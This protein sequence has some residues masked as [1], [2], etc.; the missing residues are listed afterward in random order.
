MN[1]NQILI[2]NITIDDNHNKGGFFAYPN[3]REVTEERTYE[4]NIKSVF[5]G[6]TERLYDS[7]KPT[8][9][10]TTLDDSRNGFVGSSITQVPK[11]R[12]QGYEELKKIKDK[13]K[14][15]SLQTIRNSR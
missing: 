11:E 14:F 3:E 9:K 13:S 12:L 7:V 15:N 4:G 8:I 6:E 2:E 5:N 1:Y 10:Q